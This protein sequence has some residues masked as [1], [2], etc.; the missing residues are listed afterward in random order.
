M[1][2]FVLNFDLYSFLGGCLERF[3]FRQ[4]SVLLFPVSLE[5]LLLESN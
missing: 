2:L 5:N 3:R 1:V 4:L